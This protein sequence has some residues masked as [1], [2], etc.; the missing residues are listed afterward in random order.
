MNSRSIVFTE[1]PYVRETF[2]KT[3]MGDS[4]LKT[5]GLANRIRKQL[6]QQTCMKKLQ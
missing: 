1:R 4:L 6:P 5:I 2:S 3:M